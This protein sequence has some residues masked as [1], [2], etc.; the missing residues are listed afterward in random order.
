MIIGTNSARYAALNARDGSFKWL[1][2]P[3]S[4]ELDSAGNPD[5][6]AFGT[7]P[8][9]A[10]VHANETP[11]I[12]LG[13]NV[14][15]F[16]FN[17]KPE[18]DQLIPGWPANVACRGIFVL[19]GKDGSVRQR[20]AAPQATTYDITTYGNGTQAAVVADLDNDGSV[21]FVFGGAVFNNDGSVRWNNTD[22]SAGHPVS[23]W[24][25]VGNFDDTPDI[26]VA[27]L[28]GNGS[29]G[30]GPIRLAVY[31]SNGSLLWALPLS[32]T[33]SVGI[34]VIADVDGTGRPAIVLNVGSNVCAVD[35]RGTYKWCYDA[36]T[37]DGVTPK[38]PIGIRSQVYDLDGDGV[39]EVIV[40]VNPEILLFLD[41][42]T[43]ALKYK[44]DMALANDGP[45]PSTRSGD[46]LGGPVVAD[47]DG[48]GHASIVSLWDNFGRLDVVTSQNND[49][50][51]ARKIFNQESYQYGNV[52]DDGTIPKTFVNNFATPATNVFGT[53]AQ[54]LTPVDP[55]LKTQTTFTYKANNSTQSSSPAT[56]TIEI[57][58][59]N[60]P[61]VFTSIPPTRYV[62][63]D[64]NFTY[65]A[66]AV[67]PD[68][69]DTVTYSLALAQPNGSQFCTM[70]PATS[71]LS[72]TLLS[73]DLNFIIVATDSFGAQV[74]QNIHLQPSAGPGVVPNVVGLTQAAADTTLI[75]AGFATGNVTLV[76]NAAPVGQVIAQA[77]SAGASALLGSLVDVS[78]SQG[79]APVTVPFVVGKQLQA[80]NVQLAG[81]GLTVIVNLAPSAVIPVGEVMAQSPAF[82]TLVSP[83]PANPV[84]LTVSSGAAPPLANLNH[85]VVKPA[86]AA[87]VVGEKAQF[88]A[89]GI[90]NNGT[91]A[92]FTLV[93]TWASTVPAVATIDLTGIAH[94]VGPGSTSLTATVGSFTAQGTLNVSVFVPGD[95]VPPTALITAPAS[96][97]S[98]SAPT[99]VVGTA[100]DA[101]FLRYELAVAPAGATAY[102]LIGEGTAPVTSGVLGTFDPTL[103]INDLYTIR[104]TVF[105]SGDNESVATTTVQV[106]G[107]RKV[108]VFTLTFQDLNVPASG[109][110]LTITRTYDSRDKT[111][112]DFG[113]GWR[114][115]QQTLRLRTNRVLGTGWI[116]TVSG[117]VVSLVPTSEHKVSVTTPDGRIEE[118]DMSVSPTSN[119]GSLDFTTI[120]GY[121]PR[122]GT[123]G[124]LEA[125][126]NNSMLIVSSG[127]EVELVD[128]SSFATYS[129]QLYRY[130]MVDGTQFEISP[131]AGV[132]KITD[133]N[134]NVVTFGPGGI[135]HSNG[136]GIVFTR[137]ANG[138]IVAITDP[139][140]AVRTY[141]YDG[142]GD[143]VS[144]TSAVGDVTRFSYDLNHNVVDW[145]APDGNSPMRNDYDESGRLIATTDARGNKVTFTHDVGASREIVLNRLG[146][147]T[148]IDYDVAGRVLAETDAL[149]GY[150]AFTYDSNDNKL[151]ET[152]PLSRVSTMTYDAQN[153][154]LTRTDFEG[155]TSVYT[156]NTFR[157]FLTARDP[158]GRVTTNVYDPNGNLIQVTDPEGGI[159][160]NTYDTAGNLLTSRDQLGNVTVAVYDGSGN[161][162]S[163][164]DPLGRVTTYAYD[165]NNRAI[166]NTDPAG[167]QAKIVFDASGR[168]TTSIDRLGNTTSITYSPVADGS[169]PATR[170]DAVGRLTT[171][172]YD[173][174]GNLTRTVHPDGTTELITYDAEDHPLTKTNPDADVTAFEYDQLSRLTRQTNPDGTFLSRT[175]DATGRVLTVTNERGAVSTN[176]YTP[177]VQTV[178]DAVGNVTVHKFDAKSHPTN[179]VDALGRVTTFD[180]DSAENL[181]KVTS[182]DGTFTT[183]TFD[184][185]KRKI[186]VTD[187]AGKTTQF[188]YDSS[189][190]LTRVTDAAGGMTTYAYDAAGN[191]I[192]QT[193]ANGH[194][195]QMSY[196]AIGHILS[197]TRPSGRHE[198]FA[199]D[200]SGNAVA[201][202]DFSGRTSTRAYDAMNR[203]VRENLPDGT[204]VTYAYTPSGLRAQAGGD[205]FTYDHR[206]RLVTEVKASGESITYAY[207]AAGN[208]TS[209]TTAEG[210]TAYTYDALNRLATVVAGGATTAYTYDAL[211]NQHTTSLPN[212]ITTTFVYDSLNRLIQLTNTGPGGVVSSYAYTLG[213]AGN[214]LQMAETGAATDQRTVTY[215]Y[216]SIYRLNQEGIVQPGQANQTFSY[217]YDAAGNRTQM[218]RT[219]TLTDYSYDTD[220]RLVSEVSAGTATTSTYDENGNLITRSG[221]GTT[222]SYGYDAENRLLTAFT[223]TG[224]T[225]FT[226]D[227]D[228]LRTS[229]TTGGVLTTFLVDKNRKLAEVLV[230]KTA[231][232]PVVYTYGNQLISQLR[233]GAAASF[234][235][236][237]GQLST[238]QLTNSSG[239]VTDRYTFD[240]FG[241]TLSS[242]GST[243]N[244]YLYTGE[245]LDPNVGF[246]YLRARY[247]DGQRGRFFS[248]DPEDG[249]IFD[250]MSLH[251]YLYANANPV[252]FADPSGRQIAEILAVVALVATV[253]AAVGAVAAG[254]T[255]LALKGFPTTGKGV[256]TLFV[257]V[258]GGGVGGGVS[259]V[260][261]FGP[262]I[263]GLVSLAKGLFI[264]HYIARQD[265]TWGDV[266]SSIVLDVFVGGSVGLVLQL[267]TAGFGQS[268]IAGGGAQ[269]L[270]RI[271]GG[272]VA[273]L[274]GT[275]TKEVEKFLKTG[276]SVAANSTFW[277]KNHYL[278][279]LINGATSCK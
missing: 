120:T 42:K 191:R 31:K 54:V 16:L 21:E 96:G 146:N 74:Y 100:T 89:T 140:G 240:A 48:S 166:S 37:I 26:E 85:I 103:L 72:C 205:N 65:V 108:G 250:P 252:T 4:R 234:Y 56:V 58:P 215:V 224:T 161:K 8:T 41:G 90:Y 176:A 141:A 5:S 70:A 19:D 79:P 76:F 216:D 28:E 193:D 109:L 186:A 115:G 102:T 93:V 132:K 14:S 122:P 233:P 17:G 160:S 53:Q 23:F 181:V 228:G 43:G 10:R 173:G 211:G 77:P 172:E 226:Y 235:V 163:Q 45:V 118:F 130:T 149:G 153:N 222:E 219:G 204:T 249:N 247:Y 237:D 261:G 119:I 136:T 124:K 126:V 142:N 147:Q 86:V 52:N 88:T 192:A 248:T 156:Y 246:Y 39:P 154:M 255:N 231:A 210:T 151:T 73:G 239:A 57:L 66:H 245:Q 7:V 276:D 67:D 50:R 217:S 84:T 116:R 63:P 135:L 171:F 212:G 92:D 227:A 121:I 241:R 105:D 180:Y 183:T 201:H 55:R 29:G 38:I 3:L 232:T 24:S 179:R 68:P 6:L 175:Y 143:L 267:S 60:R 64:F 95:G 138:R 91:S 182:P 202:N 82:G 144:F 71:V 150:R 128:D 194:A 174:V 2:P 104:L 129:P 273:I 158:Q 159:V 106:R 80:A 253:D 22:T 81:L 275:N 268:V 145:K 34:P 59:V 220:D 11:S 177:N 196:D 36:G 134:G 269:N 213:P 46:Y 265:I 131:T 207:D 18:C 114:L 272:F 33:P 47:L 164:T 278:P 279:T 178:T 242:A 230:E 78:V 167:R 110:P 165:A 277:C 107:A 218:N 15:Y 9:L 101:N 254:V 258:V 13:A 99:Q 32:G 12:V 123:L 137:D 113:I 35:Y 259:A 27:R 203:M 206:G 148:V 62:S 157:Q 155:N 214:R 198:A 223:P 87:R 169:K 195:T 1:S 127:D 274:T 94:A 185:A 256:A 264:T 244:V 51:P 199:Y 83:T 197:R 187:Q 117:P 168:V 162:L 44:L 262:F 271:V 189:G 200:A 225:T 190:Q 49:W 236:V 208:K 170:T 188:T 139:T 229:S 257:D 266:E 20:M 270:L 98:V 61:P 263:A 184:A 40:P 260:P 25:G 30:G 133:R 69:G 238:R 112:G 221:G 111:Q 243:P 125:L 152:D 209:L 97:S 251:R 75:G